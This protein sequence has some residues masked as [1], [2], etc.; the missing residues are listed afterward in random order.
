[1]ASSPRPC[2]GMEDTIVLVASWIEA[3]EGRGALGV[4]SRMDRSLV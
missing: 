1:M 2:V 4:A 3:G